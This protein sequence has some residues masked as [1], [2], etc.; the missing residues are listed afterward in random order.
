M[1]R[2]RHAIDELVRLQRMVTVGASGITP[3]ARHVSIAF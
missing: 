1:L 3:Y 2:A